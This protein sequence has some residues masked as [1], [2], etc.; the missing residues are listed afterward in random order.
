DAPP[1]ACTRAPGRPASRIP[2]RSAGCASGASRKA[3]ENFAERSWNIFPSERDQHLQDRS[4]PT[5]GVVGLLDILQR[6][7][8]RYQSFR[9]ALRV[10]EQLIRQAGVVGAAGVRRHQADLAEIE[11]AQVKGR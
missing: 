4:T 10:A 3:Q 6:E 8:V 2:A 7:A 5:G 1:A 11:V 9:R